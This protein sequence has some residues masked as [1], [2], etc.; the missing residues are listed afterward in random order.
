MSTK[1]RNLLISWYRLYAF[2]NGGT[3]VAKICYAKA[4]ELEKT[5]TFKSLTK[6]K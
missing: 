4:N 6:R 1:E 5:G 2:R 3:N